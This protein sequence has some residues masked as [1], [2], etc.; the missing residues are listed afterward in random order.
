MVW[1]HIGPGLNPLPRPDTPANRN[2]DRQAYIQ[3]IGQALVS[4]VHD[5]S[6]LPWAIPTTSTQICT[7][8][9]ADCQS[10]HLADLSYLMTGGNYLPGIPEDPSGG[11]VNWGSGFYISQL[12]NNEVLITAPGAE[13]GKTI[14]YTTQL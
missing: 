7:N 6:K 2:A 9:G 11:K 1:T 13:L 10:M 8:M 3:Q 4:Y 5:N 12:S 14:Q